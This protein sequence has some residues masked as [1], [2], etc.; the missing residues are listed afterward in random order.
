MTVSTTTTSSSPLIE[1]DY[2]ERFPGSARLYEQ[3]IGLMP[4]GIN[5]DVRRIEPF[6]IYIER[7]DGAYKWDVDG[8]RFIDYC[9]GHGALV[10][11]HSHP[12]VLAAIQEQ[13]S[14]VTHASAPTP[15]E[16]RW[17]ELVTEMVPSAE[18]VRFVLSG[19]E[20]TMLA[21]R[22]VRAFTGRNVIVRVD[23][24]GGNR[25][26]CHSG[27]ATGTHACCCSVTYYSTFLPD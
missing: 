23:G 18:R 24:H 26:R 20:A 8:N 11:G 9:V 17:A 5:H 19:T 21:I 3:A 22:L 4:S 14:K 25:V 27:N 10:L 13:V 12:K 15:A 1:A 6:P 2:R 7:A 16:I